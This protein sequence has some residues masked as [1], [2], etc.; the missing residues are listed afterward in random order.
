MLENLDVYV[1]VALML[2]VVIVYLANRVGVLPKK[3]LPIVLGALAAVL[4]LS[5]F[6]RWQ[7]RGL[8]SQID[9]VNR[10]IAERE[11][12]IQRL[13]LER[14]LSHDE[15]AAARARLNEQATAAMK[16]RMEIVAE[17]EEKRAVIAAASFDET[18]RLYEDMLRTEA[19][20]RTG[21]PVPA[22]SGGGN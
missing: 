1:A 9:E 4:G 16:Q 6:R 10:R 22:V 7:L 11:K 14:K 20:A 21:T 19:A 15:L 3:S 5:L 17:G 13:E 8:D 12:E 2:T 18:T